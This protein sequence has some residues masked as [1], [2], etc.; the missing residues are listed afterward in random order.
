MIQRYSPSLG[1][2][3]TEFLV[4]AVDD[5]VEAFCLRDILRRQVGP[6]SPPTEKEV[7]LVVIGRLIASGLIRAGEM[8]ADVTGLAY[9]SETDQ[10]LIQRISDVWTIDSP[11]KMGE[12]PWFHATEEGKHVVVNIKAR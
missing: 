3:A 12:S 7:A 2:I 9:W 1:A 8:R 4:W 11:P 5:F 6:L 10:A